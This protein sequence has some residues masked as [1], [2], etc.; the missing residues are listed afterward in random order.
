MG[1]AYLFSRDSAAAR[2]PLTEALSLS[3][4]SGD[5][6]TAILATASLGAVDEAE[7]QFDAAAATYRRVLQMAGDQPLQIVHEVHLGLAR[8]LYEWND[9]D[10]AERHA[11]QGLDLAKQYDRA[12]DRYIV[13]EVFL[14]RLKLAR[15]D[16]AGAAS[17]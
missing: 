5:I 4:A 13:C 6:F 3:Q 12:I 16:V 7:N 11:R 10:A 9:L 14:A 8:I 17:V 2:R 1:L 15:G